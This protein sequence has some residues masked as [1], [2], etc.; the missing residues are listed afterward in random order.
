VRRVVL[1]NTSHELADGASDF[2]PEILKRFASGFGCSR[3][4]ASVTSRHGN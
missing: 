4:T 3:A 2:P 1:S